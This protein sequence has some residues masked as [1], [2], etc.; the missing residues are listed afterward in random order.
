LLKIFL[1]SGNKNYRLALELVFY[2]SYC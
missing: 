2:S 1:K